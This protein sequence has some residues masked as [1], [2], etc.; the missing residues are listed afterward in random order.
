MDEMGELATEAA[1]KKPLPNR[2]V[3][4][5]LRGSVVADGKIKGQE[6]AS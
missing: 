3:I 6:K 5:R 1:R 4:F 2:T